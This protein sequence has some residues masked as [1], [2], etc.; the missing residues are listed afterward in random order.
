MKSRLWLE[1]LLA[2]VWL[3]AWL[4]HGAGAAWRDCSYACRKQIVVPARSV[5]SD[6]ED[7]PLLVSHAA[8][9]DLAARARADGADIL[10]TA[11][12][13]VTQLSH[14]VERYVPSTGELAAWVRVPRLSTASDTILYLYFGQ[15]A[16]G[17]TQDPQA[18]WG[19]GYEAV[20][21]LNEAGGSGCAIL[22]SARADFSGVT[23]GTAYRPA[24]AVAGARAFSGSGDERVLFSGTQV[25]FYRWPEWSI[26]FW[27]HP[28]YA[29][30]LDWENDRDARVLYRGGSLWGR[31]FRGAWMTSG[32]GHFQIDVTFGLA[33]PFYRRV[34]IPSRAWSHIVYQ[35]S[36]QKYQVLR[37]GV[38]IDSQNV[39]QDYLALNATQAFFLGNTSG[40]MPGAIDELRISRS[41]RSAAWYLAE[42]TN[43]SSPAA[44]Y[45]LGPV[46]YAADYCSAEASPV[47]VFQV[48]NAVLHPA[49][50]RPARILVNFQA[51]CRARLGVYDLTGRRVALLLDGN[52]DPRLYELAWDGGDAGS[53]TYVVHLL[54]GGRRLNRKLVLVR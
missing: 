13:G 9:A 48:E 31:T 24:G 33:G 25:L 15:P 26:E 7:F 51:P 52:V 18:V 54:A 44:F 43:Q 34:D 4:P 35:Y 16:S 23:T 19:S 39:P 36:G 21:H 46:E 5:E 37:N 1:R 50:S 6:L 45:S 32:W 53:G 42:A 29:S 12:D 49:Q 40:A 10:F 41:S 47:A 30:D 17:P 8:D 38:L 14:E 2:V 28:D 3:C 27:L 20:W 22:N 11:G